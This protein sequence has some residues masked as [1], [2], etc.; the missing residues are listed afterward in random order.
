ME[1]ASRQQTALPKEP[2]SN[3]VPMREPETAAHTASVT[4]DDAQTIEEPGYG[5][6]V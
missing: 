6:G 1:T 3:P 2:E 4:H 5:H